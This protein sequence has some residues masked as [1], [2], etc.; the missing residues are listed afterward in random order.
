M[1]A[2]RSARYWDMGQER[3]TAWRALAHCAGFM[4]GG[5]CMFHESMKGVVDKVGMMHWRGKWA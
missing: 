2:I 4:E 1:N 5:F 3:A